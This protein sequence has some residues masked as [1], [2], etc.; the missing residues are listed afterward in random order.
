MSCMCWESLTVYNCPEETAKKIVVAIM[1]D[2]VF[3]DAFS[4]D[5]HMWRDDELYLCSNN[6]INHGVNRDDDFT[7]FSRKFPEQTFLIEGETEDSCL[8]RIYLR[9]G[10]KCEYEPTLVWPEFK[11]EDLE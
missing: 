5:L 2:G 9:N 8:Y 7:E 4:W 10:R 11:P 1:N 6:A 3:S